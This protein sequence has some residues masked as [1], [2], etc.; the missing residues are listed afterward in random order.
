LKDTELSKIANASLKI[1]N[2]AV[3]QVDYFWHF[4]AKNLAIDKV[5]GKMKPSELLPFQLSIT[6]QQKIPETVQLELYLFNLPEKSLS[7]NVVSRNI[8]GIEAIQ[9]LTIEIKTKPAYSDIQIFPIHR[10]IV[11]PIY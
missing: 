8:N 2:L 6:P 11:Q 4:T 10:E 9:C 7:G 3:V 1:R 5:K